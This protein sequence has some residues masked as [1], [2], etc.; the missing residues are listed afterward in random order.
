MDYPEELSPT[1]PSTELTPMWKSKSRKGTRSLMKSGD[2]LSSIASIES[3]RPVQ[4]ERRQESTSYFFGVIRPPGNCSFLSSRLP[5]ERE[6]ERGTG[7]PST[8]RETRDFL[9]LSRPLDLRLILADCFYWHPKDAGTTMTVRF[10]SSWCRVEI[11]LPI[12]RV[13]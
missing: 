13:Y 4:R 1:I 5:R 10:R 6:R 2:R 3:P 12:I 8:G 9:A 7:G 11:S